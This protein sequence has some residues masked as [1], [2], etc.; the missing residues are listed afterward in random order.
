MYRYEDAIAN[1]ALEY[2]GHATKEL[3]ELEVF[4]G[5]IFNSTGSKTRRQRDGSMKLKDKLDRIVR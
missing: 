3:T 1:A 4:T 2:S 5:T